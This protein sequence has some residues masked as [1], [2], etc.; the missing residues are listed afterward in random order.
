[1]V[2]GTALLIANGYQQA[3]EDHSLFI[4]HSA[5]QFT[6]LLVYIDD[7]ILTGNS[8]DEFTFIKNILHHSFKI[9]DLGQLKYFWVWRLHIQNWIFLYVRGNT[10]WICYLTQVFWI[11]NLWPPLHIL[12]SNYVMMTLLH[13]KTFLL[14]EDFLEDYCTWMQ[15][16]QTL[17][18]SLTN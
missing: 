8:L 4:K 17:P 18:S 7:I 13:T 6:T 9:K 5:A 14:T 1:M 3:S 11:Q 2:W 16:D 12:P 10:V 15:P